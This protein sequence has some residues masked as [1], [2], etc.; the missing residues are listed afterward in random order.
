MNVPDTRARY[1]KTVPVSAR[2]IMARA[3]EG[4]ASPRQAIKA[5]CLNCTC[6]D[7]AEIENCVVVMCPLY[8]YRPAFGRKPAEGSDSCEK[9]V[10][11]ALTPIR[12]TF[13]AQRPGKID[14]VDDEAAGEVLTLGAREDSR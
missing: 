13:A 12:A 11:E 10:G 9:R 7:R 2:R 6:F 5:C 3:F 8:A 4:K 14:S 1:L